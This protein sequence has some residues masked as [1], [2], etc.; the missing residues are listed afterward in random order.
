VYADDTIILLDHDLEQARNLKIMLS[1]FEQLS[2]L[3]INFDK[4]EMFCYGKAKDWHFEYSQIFGCELGAMPFRY[5]GISMHHKRLLNSDWKDVLDKFK[6]RLSSWKSKLLSVSGRLTLLNSILS[7]RSLFMFSFFE[8][9]KEVLKKIGT[10][11]SPFF[12]AK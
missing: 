10:F 3:K 9:P 2:G 4:S 8:V 6:K 11:R 5:L 12:L 7:S 1:V